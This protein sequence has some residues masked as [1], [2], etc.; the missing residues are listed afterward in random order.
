MSGKKL[1]LILGK[2]NRQIVAIVFT[3]WGLLLRFQKLADR[4][5]WT[6]ELI[7]LEATLDPFFTLLNPASPRSDT[8]GFIGDYLLTYY[9]V[10][11][12]GVNKLAV[13]I[14]H[15]IVTCIGF[16]FFY[17]ICQKYFKTI[18]GFIIAYA[19]VCFNSQ[20]IYYSF[21]IRPYAVLPTLALGCFHSMGELLEKQSTL[22][23]LR[24]RVWL[25]IFF[26]VTILFHVY[27]ILI[28][29][30]TG[31]FHVIN[32]FTNYSIKDILKRYF[33][34]FGLIL[35]I[36]MPLWAWFSGAIIHNLGTMKAFDTFA[37]IPSPLVD[38]IGFLKGIFCNLIGYKPFYAAFLGI[39]L[40]FLIPHRER[41]RQIGFFLVL[42]IFPLVCLLLADLY[43]G[44]WFLQRQFTWIMPLFAFFLGWCWD[45]INVWTYVRSWRKA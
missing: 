23:S 1:F 4:E 24:K 17:L 2:Y 15:I 29:F 3:L 16:Y 33:K 41:N 5:L 40:A 21:E 25:S 8:T 6:D 11:F 31:I 13:A 27:G 42:V 20:L 12:F 34:F 9:F 38:P 26:T 43:L 10:R 45:S 36:A 30:T 37:F 35:L 14:P 28:V 32:Q 18:W 44:Y 22:V 7:Q 19:I 39:V